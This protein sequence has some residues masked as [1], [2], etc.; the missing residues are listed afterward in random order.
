MI[1]AL[2]VAE[3]NTRDAVDVRGKIF[4]NLKSLK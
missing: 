4:S 3:K 1:H 2:V